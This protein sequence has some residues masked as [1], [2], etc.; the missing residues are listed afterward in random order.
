MG[1]YSEEEDQNVIEYNKSMKKQITYK[2]VLEIEVQAESPLQAAKTVQEWVRDGGFQFYVQP[3]DKSE[4][5]FSVD[6]SE[7]DENAVLETLNYTPMIK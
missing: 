2:V 4:K 7:E 3:C 6:L 1:I 5:V